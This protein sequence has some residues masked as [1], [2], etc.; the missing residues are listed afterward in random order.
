MEMFFVNKPMAVL[1]ESGTVIRI[2]K[3]IG[4]GVYECRYCTLFS[5]TFCVHHSSMKEL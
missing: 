5:G 3:Y 4:D 2:G 1:K